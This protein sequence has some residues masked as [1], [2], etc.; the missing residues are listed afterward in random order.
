MFMLLAK[1]LNINMH[2][3]KF[4]SSRLAQQIE[5]RIALGLIEL[6]VQI[7]ILQYECMYFNDI[8]TF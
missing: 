1:G 8:K 5:M 3:T 7:W 2:Y 6:Q 4:Q